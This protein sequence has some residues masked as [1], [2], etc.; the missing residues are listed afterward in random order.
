MCFFFIIEDDIAKFPQ[1]ELFYISSCNCI[2]FFFSCFEAIK[3]YEIHKLLYLP[4]KL[5]FLYFGPLITHSLCLVTPSALKSVSPMIIYLP[6]L[7]LID[8]SLLY[9]FIFTFI[10]TLCLGYALCFTCVSH[11]LQTFEIL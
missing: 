6:R 7:L 8:N 2:S 9:L 4:N 11:K 3:L 10:L 5:N 1:C